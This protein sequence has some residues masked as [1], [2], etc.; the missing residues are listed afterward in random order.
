MGE[1]ISYTG[2]NVGMDDDSL[3]LREQRWLLDEKYNSQESPEYNQDL[4]QL[5]SGVPVDYLIGHREFL[6]CHIDLSHHPLIPRNETE[7]WV[8]RV[9]DEYHNTDGLRILDIFAG[10][11]CIGIAALQHLFT[12]TVD[13]VE[14]NRDFIDQIQKNL[15]INT[16]DP[17]RYTVTQSD[18]F[19]QLEDQ[20][21]DLIMANPPYIAHNRLDTVQESVHDYEDHGSLYADDDGLF[22]IKKLIDELPHRLNPGGSCYIEYDPWQTDHIVEYIQTNHP[23]LSHRI[24]QDQFEKD[25][26]V[27][28]QNLT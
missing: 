12:S 7:Y 2:Y 14:Y 15:E 4:E 24:I 27:Q 25:R 21:Y 8:K 10:S 16:I 26:V 20:Q 28:I 13:F 19:T 1:I 17:S 5:A 22:F 23:N 6:G 18:M 11:G 9:L 3:S